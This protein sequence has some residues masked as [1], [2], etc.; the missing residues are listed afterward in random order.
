MDGTPQGPRD[1]P[2][3]NGAEPAPP[4][5][6]FHPPEPPEI[7]EL[8][9]RPVGHPAGRVAGSG[10][11]SS[12]VTGM[13]KAWGVAMDF[14]FTIIGSALLGYFADR[15]QNTSPLYTM[16]GLAGG[17]ALALVRIIRRTI[18]DD[19]RE[20]QARENARSGRRDP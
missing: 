1:L 2:P 11:E 14:V 18:A 19:R 4:P 10:G 7:P 9:R 20:S 17:F 12:A 16:I 8:L 3:E 15:W 6:P 5:L 13:G